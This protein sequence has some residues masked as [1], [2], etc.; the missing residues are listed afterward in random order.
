MA[1]APLQPG[2]NLGTRQT[3]A[4]IGATVLD[5]LG[6]PGSLAG[7]SFWPQIQKR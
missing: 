4:D 3:F 1:G 5:Y 2:V 6:V 7:A